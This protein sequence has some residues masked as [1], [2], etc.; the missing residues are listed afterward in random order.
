M[1]KFFD[2]KLEE[3]G[4][5]RVYDIGFSDASND[6]EGDF[7]RWKEKLWPALIERYKAED[8]DKAKPDKERKQHV[9]HQ[10]SKQPLAIRQYVKGQ[11]VKIHSVRELRQTQKYGSCLE[12]I[13]DLDGT[14]LRYKTA[15]NLA[16]FATNRNQDVDTILG[17]DDGDVQLTDSAFP[18]P[19]T[20]REAFTKYIDLTGPLDRGLLK[21]L[22]AH[23]EDETEKQELLRLGNPEGKDDL[24]ALK[25]ELTTAL[26][27]L[28]KYKSVKLTAEQKLSVLPKM[29]PRYYTIASSAAVSPT[30][31]RIA[32]SLTEFDSP[33][34]KKFRGLASEFF[35]RI[36]KKCFTSEVPQEVKARIFFHDSLFKLPESPETPIIMVGPGTGVVPFI[37]FSEEREYLKLHNPDSKFGA[38]HLYFGCKT[39]NDDYIFKEEIANFK[40]SYSGIIIT[41]LYE[42]F[43][44]EQDHKVY[45]QDIIRDQTRDQI[46]DLILNQNAHF[47]L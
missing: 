31:V 6:A 44:R 17:D 15:A 24:D 10:H 35:D 7:A 38:A 1:G 43:S 33:S 21:H 19:C 3:L 23:A 30:K 28:A 4:G 41:D 25:H 32:I 9:E 13:F 29:V 45:V 42:A 16:V 39:R 40:Q 22:S 26:D 11:D 5:N 18:L 14:D 20:L 12:V 27:L 47:Y 8:G 2:E 36:F 46:K 37:A 34:G